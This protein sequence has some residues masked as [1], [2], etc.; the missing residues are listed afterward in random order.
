MYT[1][2]SNNVKVITV[3]HFIGTVNL[4]LLLSQGKEALACFPTVVNLG[5][6]TSLP[7]MCY[8]KTGLP[9]GSPA[10]SK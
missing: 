3:L 5:L 6:Y 4:S 7:R 9:L 8:K 10:I 1:Y 2:I